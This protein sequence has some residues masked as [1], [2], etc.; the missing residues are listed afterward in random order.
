V[1]CISPHALLSALVG[2]LERGGPDARAD[3][4]VAIVGAGCPRADVEAAL[5][6]AS[7]EAVL[8]ARDLL[9]HTETPERAARRR[10]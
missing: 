8:R 2:R 10:V 4:L 6:R 7:G 1:S 5:A 9:A 3:E